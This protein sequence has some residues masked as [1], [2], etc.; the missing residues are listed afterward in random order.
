[1][2]PVTSTDERR[3]GAAPTRVRRRR[4]VQRRHVAAALAALVLASFASLFIGVG[5]LTPGDVLDPD[6]A[7]ARVLW[8]SRVPRLLAILLAGSAMAVAGLVMMHLTR[9]RFVSPQTAGT[10]EWVGLGIVVATLWL[11]GT[12]VLGKMAIGMLF[13]LVGTGF[14]VWLLQR[15]VLTDVVVVPLV[16]ILLG[17]VVSAATT[18]GSNWVPVLAM[19]SATAS[20]RGMAPR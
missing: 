3:S 13:A 10:T 20:S 9:N 14:F 15:L 17:G 4:G 5:D 12:S 8:T 19:I 11:G 16:G 6:A 7:Q 1:M 2:T 18:F